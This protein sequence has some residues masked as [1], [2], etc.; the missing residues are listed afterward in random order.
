MPRIFDDVAE[1]VETTLSRV[2]PH[3]V[4][5]L[6]LGIG[7]PNPLAN[8]F[9]RRARRDPKLTLKIFTALSL[10][11]PQWKGELE[12][13]FLEPLVARL[14]GGCVPL[15]YVT[16]LHGAGVPDNVQIVEFFLDPG[17]LLDVSHSQRHYVSTNYT[18]VARDVA[19]QGV[20]VVG[21]LVAKR[22]VDGR[23]EYSLGSNPDVTVDLLEHLAPQRRLGRDVVVIGEVNR[24]MPF[25]YGPAAVSADTFDSLIEHPR[26]D[27]DLFAPPNQRLGTVDYA[28]GLYGARLIRD[29]GTLQIGIGELGD[30]VVY[31]LQLRQQ[32]NAEFREILQ[33]LKAQE[34]F[35][36]SLDSIGG[37][38][39][40]EAGLYACTEMFVDGFLDLY[41]SGVLRRRVYDDARIQRMLNE[42]AV[43]ERIDERF[44]A[45]LAEAGFASPVTADEFALL[46]NLGVF[47]R[48]CRYAGG[49]IENAEGQSAAAVFNTEAARRE[50]LELC[51]GRTL[52]GGVLLH[53]GFFLGPRG[54]YAALRD[55]PDLERRQFSMCGVSFVNQLDGADQALKIAQRA[56]GRFINSSM[57]VTLLGAAVSDG[58]ADGR[59]VSGVGGQYN[60]VAMAHALPEARSI[61]TLRSTRD[62]NSTLTSNI[63]WSYGNTT[64]PRHLRDIVVT[65]YGV[66]D[67]RGLSDQDVIAAMLN[68][69]D[70]RFQDGLKR[71]A[72]AAGKLRHDHRIPD[73]HRNNTPRALEER[74]ILARARGLFS[75]FPFGS[76]F[77]R[78]EIVLAK[79]LTRLKQRTTG[80]WPR[81]KTLLGAATIRGI[82]TA[83][84]PYLER[85]S[86]GAPQT[87]QEWLW[88]RLL[89]QELRG[90]T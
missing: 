77:T 41:R 56:H 54:F 33:G 18:H 72:Q 55:L 82:P 69:A 5:A 7:K 2:G 88:Q 9:Y 25:M 6:P 62:K 14:F 50:L 51:T 59:V 58:L 10:R 71:E 74:F 81:V 46:Q 87:R 32:Q 70:S 22:S 48:D 44:L 47:R 42:G 66:A 21:Q 12:R 30:A 11:A 84:R 76:D 17:A 57:M 83:I 24:Q 13:R 65:E 78:E 27:Y 20:N 67:L 60:F 40:F 29:G 53:G 8:E 86:L 68:I 38:S 31:G 52:S 16:D 49:R 45:A 64:I 37:A 75:E 23:A 79:A 90:M 1:C 85:M 3:I 19:A 34:R 73:M 28:I 26:Y 89:V 61:L 35:G 39:S 80:G 36:E 63:L 4:L 15:D 43:S